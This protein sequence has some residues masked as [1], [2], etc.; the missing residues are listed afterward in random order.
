MRKRRRPTNGSP[1]QKGSFKNFHPKVLMGV[2]MSNEAKMIHVEENFAKPRVEPR[3]PMAVEHKTY[4]YKQIEDEQ[5]DEQ[6]AIISCPHAIGYHSDRLIVVDLEPKSSTYCQVV[7]ELRLPA[8][9]DE[10]GRINWAKSADHLHDM[11]KINR[12][13]MIVP[14]MNSSKIYV[15][16][17]HGGTLKLEKEISADTLLRKDVSCP[18]AVRSLPLKG[19][20]IH[21]STLGDKEGHGKGDF[22]LLDRHTWE[23][24]K[25]NDSE[26]SS[27]GGDFALQPRHNLLISCEWGHPR[28][29]RNGFTNSDLENVSESLGNQLHVWQ[30]SPPKLKQ[31]IELHPFDGCLTST[32]RF[33]HNADCNHAFACSA[34]GSSLF[35]IHMDS[36]TQEWTADKVAQIPS[37]RVEHWQ[38]EEIP[39]ILT[40]MVISM[41]DQFLFLAGYLHGIIWKFDIQDPFRV[42]LQCK[43]SLGGVMTCNPE[44]SLKTSCA[45][46]DMW[47]LPPTKI[48][49]MRGVD[50]RG[51][52]ASMQLSKDGKRLYVCNSFYKA[53]DA[54]F[55]P[56]LISEGGQM[57]K[58]DVLQ[59]QLVLDENFLIEIKDDKEGPFVVRDIRF[60]GGDCTSDNFL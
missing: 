23:V 33:L 21:I 7:N 38:C 41:D 48:A 32:V 2:C 20:P 57:I 40:D 3:P 51:G 31:T 47:W 22:V 55:Y 53:W 54:Q 43:I 8:N 34:I 1:T 50:F 26:F 58:I 4:D 19:A 39:A 28:L 37:L 14:C 35:H 59:D 29:F 11:Q 15:V 25:K 56:E 44:V 10:P 12:R 18:Y 30:I 9:G 52:P 17:A 36:L 16:E 45:L 13:Y 6:F 5:D 42:S 27:F 24:R 46:E 60:F 49:Q